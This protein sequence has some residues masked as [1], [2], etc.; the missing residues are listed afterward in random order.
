VALFG[1]LGVEDDTRALPADEIEALMRWIA[2]YQEWRPVLHAGTLHQGSISEALTWT[3]AL[4][5]D[6]SASLIDN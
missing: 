4:S 1:H 6:G 2:L 3:Q 5:D